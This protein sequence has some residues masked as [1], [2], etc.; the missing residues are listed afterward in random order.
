MNTGF[1][2]NATNL[3]SSPLRK[4]LLE[5]FTSIFGILKNVFASKIEDS[6]KF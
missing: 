2:M 1:F 5:H 4:N 6:G 3:F